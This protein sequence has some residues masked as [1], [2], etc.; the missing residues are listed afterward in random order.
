M[1]NKPIMPWLLPGLSCSAPA[2][3]LVTAAQ[4]NPTT[5]RAGDVASQPLPQH[6]RRP[7]HEEQHADITVHG[8]E[9]CVHARE[10]IRFH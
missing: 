6:I 3:E 8:E 1:R 10:V 2:A 9:G 5:R 7:K 4:S